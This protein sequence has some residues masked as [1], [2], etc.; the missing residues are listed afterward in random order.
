M[1]WDLF[2]SYSK[3]VFF[4]SVK[5]SLKGRAR[6]DFL[7]AWDCFPT[8]ETNKAM[9]ADAKSGKQGK[10]ACSIFLLKLCK[11]LGRRH[12]APA[13]LLI[14]GISTCTFAVLSFLPYIG[15]ACAASTA[16]CLYRWHNSSDSESEPNTK[17]QNTVL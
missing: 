2:Q 8:T 14:F 17:H 3:N 13:Q 5:D 12:I 7:H 9:K 6:S 11:F 10:H 16:R 15:T 1:E 4:W